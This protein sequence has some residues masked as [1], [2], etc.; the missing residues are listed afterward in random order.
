MAEPREASNPVTIGCITVFCAPLWVTGLL[1][2]INGIRADALVPA[3]GGIAMFGAGVLP[4]YLVIA[5]IRLQPQR[6]AL[7]K[8][9]RATPA[10]WKPEWSAGRLADQTVETASVMGAMMI[11]LTGMSLLCGFF[12]FVA[13]RQGARAGLVM[14]VVPLVLV[15]FVVSRIRFGMR[16]KRFGKSELLLEETLAHIGAT[17]RANLIVEKLR[18]DELTART[19]KIH[20]TSIRR[21]E[22]TERQGGSP[23]TRV[24]SRVLWQGAVDVPGSAAHLKEDGLWL[25]IA[26][27]IP[28][29]QQATNDALENDKVYWQLEASSQLPGIDYYSRFEIP[30]FV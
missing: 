2:T 7:Y 21:K 6:K 26:I 20:V 22:W 19:F 29:D 15:G 18:P 4:I 9:I 3:I 1:T 11:V 25:P 27:E 12:A 30:V 28:K 23:K 17:M 13:V 5:S 16:R 14:L 10:H 24:D 8:E